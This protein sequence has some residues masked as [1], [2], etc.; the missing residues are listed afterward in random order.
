MRLCGKLHEKTM[1]TASKVSRCYDLAGAVLAFM[2]AHPFCFYRRDGRDYCDD[3]FCRLLV[4]LREQYVD[5]SFDDFAATIQVPLDTLM[6]WL[7]LG[8]DT[9]STRS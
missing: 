5:V 3:A 8:M 2:M 7:D 1:P 4:E 6:E 9:S